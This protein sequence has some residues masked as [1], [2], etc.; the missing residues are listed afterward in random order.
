MVSYPNEARETRLR[1]AL[2]T[3]EL[4]RQ[5]L[6]GWAILSPKFN[7]DISNFESIPIIKNA[8]GLPYCDKAGTSNQTIFN[9]TLLTVFAMMN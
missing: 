7:A 1:W 9:S 2:S 6:Y 3:E 5:M 4:E 8:N